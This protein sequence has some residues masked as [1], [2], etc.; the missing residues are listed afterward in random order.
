MKIKC[1]INGQT[2]ELP[3]FMVHFF[4]KKSLIYCCTI[5][6]NGK[7]SIQPIVFVNEEGKCALTFLVDKQSTMAKN[8]RNNPNL[9]LTIDETHPINPFW[10]T[11]VMIKAVSQLSETQKE[12]RK[13]FENLQ[14][15]YSSDTIT[16]IL[17]IDAIQKSIRLKAVPLEIVYWKNPIFKRFRCKQRRRKTF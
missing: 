2:C 7:L 16:K 8:L 15:K 9:S 14:K 12:I 6:E 5:S 13:C 17:G 10:N 1:E 3:D 11:G 4:K